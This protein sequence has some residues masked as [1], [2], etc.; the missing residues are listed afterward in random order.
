MCHS[1]YNVAMDS[2]RKDLRNTVVLITIT[3]IASL[4]HGG[5]ACLLYTGAVIISAIVLLAGQDYLQGKR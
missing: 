4:N 5:N 1:E 3:L 2:T